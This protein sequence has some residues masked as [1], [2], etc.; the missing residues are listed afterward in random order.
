MEQKTELIDSV[1][2]YKDEKL[3]DKFT[4]KDSHY[5]W[6]PNTIKNLLEINGF[7]II[8][9]AKTDDYE[10]KANEDDWKIMLIA[11]KIHQ[12]HSAYK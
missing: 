11:R 6:T 7:E 4:H 12:L 5:L 8:K 1:E 10:T 9:I 3:I 2:V